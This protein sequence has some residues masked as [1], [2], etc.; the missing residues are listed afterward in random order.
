MNRG[1]RI[2][3]LGVLVSLTLLLPVAVNAATL[4][5]NCD[6]KKGLTRIAQAISIVRHNE[7]QGVNTIL[8][9]GT[10]RENITIQ[11]M[12]NLTL[13]AQNGASITDA[14]NGSADVVDIVDSRR[15]SINGFTI[16]GGANG[17]LCSN[18]SLC[19]FSS[20]TIQNSSGTGVWALASQVRFEGDTLQN[21]EARG[22]SVVNGSQAGGDSLTVQGNG[23]G[24]L[25]LAKGTLILTN[26]VVQGNQGFGIRAVEGSTIRITA[27]TITANHGNGVELDQATQARFEA[28][29]DTNGITNNG[30]VGVFLGD[31]SFAAFDANSNVTNNGGGT[32]VV[33]GTQFSATRGALTNIGG[34]TTNCTE[35]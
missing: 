33:C 34:G 19:R 24:V 23:N 4:R 32:D 11:S 6:S 20:N 30:G 12:D 3:Y 27:S 7:L 1:M 9:S 8:V 22:L 16:S 18:Y 15:I 10:C 31:L 13:T 25:I 5:V 21:H 35:P 26:A 2:S 17:V 28:F 29:S 14:S